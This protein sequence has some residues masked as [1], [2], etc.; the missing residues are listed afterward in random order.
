MKKL[1]LLLV[2]AA[3]AGGGWYY[4]QGKKDD[5]PEYQTA[6]VTRGD[7][8]QAVTATGTLNPVMNVQ[9]GSQISGNI[10]Q[11]FADFNTE[12]KAGQVVAQ[13]DPATFEAAVHQAEGDLANAKAVLQLA[14]V[15]AKRKAELVE[16]K[17]APQ[18]DLDNAQAVLSQAEAS[19]QMKTANLEKAKVDLGRCTI[20]SPIDGIVISRNVDVGQTV[21]ATMN[22]PVLF[23]I[24]NDLRK[25]QIN[26]AIAEADI[27]NIEAGQAVEFT[28]DAF[29]ARTF[30]GK[31][32][33]VRNAATTVQNVVTYDTVISVANDDL[34]LKPGMTANISVI[35]AQRQNV[36]RL[37]NAAL[38]FRPPES[39]KTATTSTPRPSE[40]GGGRDGRRGPGG[41]PRERSGPV[42]RTVFI[43]A[44]TEPKPAPVKLGISDGIQTEIL[45]GL[46]ENDTVVT[47]MITK[48]PTAPPT[49]A[50]PFGG[51]RRPF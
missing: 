39:V 28:V 29:P 41:R 24:A 31:V 22:A 26:A 5:A 43:L 46:N 7:L 6:P 30:H 23:T 47:G 38:R 16:E 9:V 4:F 10:K 18:A 37:P 51:G 27:G 40:G 35:I 8:T 1:L 45:D 33:Q 36:L 11:L 25:M 3:L 32:A 13:L 19:V 15:T 44:S 2:V 49:G 34:K 48:Q 21:A 14:R 20:Y 42:E 17:A 12:V 50:S